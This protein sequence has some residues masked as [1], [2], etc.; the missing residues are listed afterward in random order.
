[1]ETHGGVDPE[2]LIPILEAA[3]VLGLSRATLKRLVVA[4]E[5]PPPVKVSTRRLAFR[6]SDLVAFQ[7]GRK[8]ASW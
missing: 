8:Q 7:D 6:R 5:L 2:T 4:R 1:M 3:H